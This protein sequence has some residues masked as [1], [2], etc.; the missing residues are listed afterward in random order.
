M[1]ITRIPP[2]AARIL[3]LA[4]LALA[5]LAALLLSQ[6]RTVA[7]SYSSGQSVWPAYEGWQKHPDGSIDF[8]FG[9]MNDNWEEEIDVPVG[10]ENNIQPGGPD[11]GQPAH[12]LPRRNRFVFRVRAPKGFGEK[13]EMVWTLATHGKTQ[14]AYATLRPD[15]LLEN[16]DLMSETGA[17][18]PGTSSPELRADKAPVVKI[19]GNRNPSVKAGQP[20]AL[21]AYVT[22]DG[23]PRARSQVPAIPRAAE[24]GAG[25]PPVPGPVPGRG[26][27]PA[28]NPPARITVGKVVGLHLSWF[29]YRGAG[30]VTFEPGQTKVWEDTRAGANSPWAPL[31]VPPQPPPDGKWVVQATFDD[32]GTY[33]LRA[34]AD[35]GALLGDDELTVTVTR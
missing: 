3:P 34:R 4:S 30:R 5:A 21:V 35:D 26:R 31:W 11:Q 18:G 7:Q 20:L 17:L 14:K 2:A 28:L 10:P 24:R 12:F 8:L 15:Y 13:E 6:Q 32:P 19:E 29:V 1:T 16:I 9:Y 33:V 27:N 22:D 25:P 23:I